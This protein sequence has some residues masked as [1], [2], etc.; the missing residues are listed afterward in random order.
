VG[1]WLDMAEPQAYY[2]ADIK[3]Y[4]I[5]GRIGK[6]AFAEV[7]KAYCKSAQVNVA[8]KVIE[9]EVENPSEDPFTKVMTESTLMLQLSH[10]NIVSSLR[11]FSH[12]S[13]VWIVMPMLVASC[14]DILKN[15]YPDG[16]VEERWIARIFV[17]VVNGLEYLHKQN[18]VHRDLKSGNILLDHNGVARIADFGVSGSLVQELCAKKRL[19]VTG[20]PC[21]MAP[22]VAEHA[23]G[24][25]SKADIWSLGITCLEL[26]CGKPPYHAHTAVKAMMKIL[27]DPPPTVERFV[28]K[29][30]TNAFRLFVESCLQK[31]P[32]NRKTAKEL[33]NAAFLQNPMDH[34]EL[35]SILELTNEENPYQR[36]VNADHQPRSLQQK[37]ED[38]APPEHSTW[39]FTGDHGADLISVVSQVNE[40]RKNLRPGQFLEVSDG[41]DSWVLARVSRNDGATITV[42][43]LDQTMGSVNL[44]NVRFSKME[45]LFENCQKLFTGKEGFQINPEQFRKYL[46][47]LGL[48]HSLINNALK[49]T[50]QKN[51]QEIISKYV[52]WFLQ[53]QSELT[54]ITPSMNTASR[55][56]VER[57][58]H[59]DE[60]TAQN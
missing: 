32:R 26:I 43:F 37:A 39:V 21:W 59:S 40:Q 28:K 17:D 15:S 16:F 42:M 56:Q 35:A 8:I 13:E 30:T 11:T 48:S 9:L 60:E 49:A 36:N 41:G 23:A 19:T 38:E 10:E 22:E 3:Q 53:S 33:K 27:N 12:R 24:H 20:T 4:D 25:D 54:Q 52:V 34:E 46:F 45:G 58:D 14:A 5:H 50:N 51:I 44:S 57:D 2:P 7:Y 18:T 47:H 55:F 31:Q 29:P 1:F 6:G